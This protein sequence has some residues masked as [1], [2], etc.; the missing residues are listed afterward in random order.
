MQVN[1][2][3]LGDGTILQDNKSIGKGLKSIDSCQVTLMEH[4]FS[5]SYDQ[6]FVGMFSCQSSRCY[7]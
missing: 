5:N 2:P 7:R 6:P 1:Y 4:V 3:I